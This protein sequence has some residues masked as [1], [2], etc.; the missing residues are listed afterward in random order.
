MAKKLIDSRFARTLMAALLIGV[1]A[2]IAHAEMSLVMPLGNREVG[3]QPFCKSILPNTASAQRVDAEATLSANV[4]GAVGT[5]QTGAIRHRAYLPSASNCGAVRFAV[6][7]DYGG[8]GQ[9]ER[10]VANLVMSW[11]PDLIITTGDNNYSNGAAR[12]IDLNIG[13]FY[14]PFI[15]YSFSPFF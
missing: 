14:S 11:C 1:L 15:I 8:H 9:A 4:A 7:G 13:Q 3:K 12:T 2:A 5:A 6:I 10:D